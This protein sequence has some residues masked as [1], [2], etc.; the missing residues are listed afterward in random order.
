M[1][2]WQAVICSI[3]LA[4]ASMSQAALLP[5]SVVTE[6]AAPHSSMR[7]GRV[8][9]VSADFVRQMAGEAGY[10]AEI[11]LLSWKA[12]LQI[13]DV[14]A[15]VMIYPI[16]R[17][18]EREANYQWIGRLA[19]YKTYFYK[20]KSRHDIQLR[21]LE[22]G[23]R[24]RV[25]AVRKD[26]RSEYLQSKGYRTGNT[27][28][29]IEVSDNRAALQLLRFGRV[30]LIPSSAISLQATCEAEGTD[31]GIFEPVIA[32]GLDIEIY[33]AM[34]KLTPP[35]QVQALRKAYDKLV[36]NGSFQ[37]TLGHTFP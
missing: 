32:I 11:R 29:L 1:K 13:A 25:A 26:V 14:Q 37:K 21:Q 5:L 17:T 30:D 3:A 16:A 18:A 35:A 33:V 7:N 31:C 34:N 12:A 28:G 15:G 27:D 20:L 10:A 24:L 9:G 8:E 19:T 4:A 23:Q 2:R 22:D 6:D 36:E